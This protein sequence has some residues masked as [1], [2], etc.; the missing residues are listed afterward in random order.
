MQS[1]W[2]DCFGNNKLIERYITTPLLE[3]SVALNVSINLVCHTHRTPPTKPLHQNYLQGGHTLFNAA[4]SV[5]GFDCV[6]NDSP[7]RTIKCYK[8]VAPTIP[9]SALTPKGAENILVAG[10]CVSSDRLANSALRVQASCMAMGQVAGCV[11]A[12]AALEN[13]KNS[14]VN[15]DKIRHTLIAHKAIVPPKQS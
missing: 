2:S 8:G 5:F 14:E 15:L 7:E 13:K 11:S 4:D 1:W 12:I 6:S 9:L 3:L 10:R